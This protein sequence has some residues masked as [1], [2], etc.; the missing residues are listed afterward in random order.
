M[1]TNIVLNESLVN[2]AMKLSGLKTKKSVIEEALKLFVSIQK[3]TRLKSLKGKLKWEGNLDEM[4]MDKP[5]LSIRIS[6]A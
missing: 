3:Q 4:R 2:D 5:K 6:I 1:R